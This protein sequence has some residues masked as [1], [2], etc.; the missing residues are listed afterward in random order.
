MPNLISL[1]SRLSRVYAVPTSWL[2][3]SSESALVSSKQDGVQMQNNLTIF[4][5]GQRCSEHNQRNASTK[6]ASS[7]VNFLLNSSGLCNGRHYE[8]V[9]TSQEDF[10]IYAGRGKWRRG[11]WKVRNRS[12]KRSKYKVPLNPHRLYRD[13]K[14]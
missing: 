10:T 6:P 7:C 5:L 1:F 12:L 14:C 9:L 8:S 2:R 3:Q 4:A 11:R 13:S